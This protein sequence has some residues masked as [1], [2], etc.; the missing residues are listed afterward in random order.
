MSRERTWGRMIGLAAAAVVASGL[1]GC[2]G[3]LHP[4][5]CER[6]P[7]PVVC[8]GPAGCRDHFYTYAINGLDPMCWHV[9]LNDD[10]SLGRDEVDQRHWR[11][12]FARHRG[13]E[14]AGGIGRQLADHGGHNAWLGRD[15]R[16]NGLAGLF[17]PALEAGGEPLWG[18][19]AGGDGG[20]KEDA[21]GDE[22]RHDG[23]ADGQRKRRARP[24]QPE[25]RSR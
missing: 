4:L 13:F 15:R 20:G 16:G 11:G 2:Y 17:H 5:Q 1:S 7:A 8:T 10:A 14:D 19:A 9:A 22:T 3:L 6:P 25:R 12:R 23:S 24:S 21:A 18:A